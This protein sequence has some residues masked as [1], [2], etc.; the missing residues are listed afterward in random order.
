MNSWWELGDWSGH[1][2][3]DLAVHAIVCP[4]CYERGNFTFSHRADKK[5]PSSVSG[6]PRKIQIIGLYF[7]RDYGISLV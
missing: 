1:H 3:N 7:E 5:K 4:F 6:S 2:G